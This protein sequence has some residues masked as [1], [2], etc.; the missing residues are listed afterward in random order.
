MAPIA[1]QP[2]CPEGRFRVSVEGAEVKSHDEGHGRYGG[3]QV[4]PRE[5][6]KGAVDFPTE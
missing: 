6:G 4:A 1:K 2:V 5:G 3:E